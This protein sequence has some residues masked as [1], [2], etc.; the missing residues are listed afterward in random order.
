MALTTME[1]SV[2]S[3][4]FLLTLLL[5]IGL[6]FFIRASVKDRTQ[7]VKLLAEQPQDAALEALKQYFVQRAY[8]VSV[9]DAVQRQVTLEGFV[10]PSLWLAVFLSGLAAIG[11]LC[12]ALVLSI[13]LPRF[14]SVLLGFVLLS[15]IAGIFYW[16]QAARPEKVLLQAEP[17]SQGNAAQSIITVTAHR[18]ELAQL[19]RS[20]PL[21]A[22][23]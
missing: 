1:T 23:K 11:G 14:S 19:Q 12:L 6:L 16:R 9:E 2:L 4:T 10:R 8:L 20:L 13:L 15:P 3:S 22:V 7:V 17:A 18:D 5:L 21:Q